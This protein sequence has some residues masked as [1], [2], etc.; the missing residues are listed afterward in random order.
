MNEILYRERIHYLLFCMAFCR[1]AMR[2]LWMRY[3][4]RMWNVFWFIEFN[5]QFRICIR[6]FFLLPFT[7]AL[8]SHICFGRLFQ[9]IYFFALSVLRQRA[10]GVLLTSAFCYLFTPFFFLFY[11]KLSWSSCSISQFKDKQ[12]IHMLVDIFQLC[13]G[14]TH[15][16]LHTNTK[17]TFVLCVLCASAV[18]SFLFL[19]MFNACIGCKYVRLLSSYP[20]YDNDDWTHTHTN[21]KVDVFMCALTNFQCGSN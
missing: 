21:K 9:F 5:V 7:L 16:V 12:I 10:R 17:I 15:N 4:N 11:S 1:F 8:A 20:A 19:L 6:F 18:F 14:S 13:D 3:I 2:K